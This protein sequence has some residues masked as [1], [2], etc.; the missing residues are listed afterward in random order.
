MPIAL[1]ASSLRRVCT[2]YIAVVAAITLAF[3]ALNARVAHPWI[4]G[5]WLI[6]YSGGFLRRGLLGALLLAVHQHTHLP[7]LPLTSALQITLYAAFYTSLLPL[8]RGLRWSLPLLTLLL[9]PAT[10]AFTVLDPPTSVRKEVLL[11]LALSLL[12][13]LVVSRRTPAWQLSLAL[14]IAAPVLILAH[15]ALLAFLPYLF[16]PLLLATSH[17]RDAARF[18]LP[19]I[20][21]AALAFAA[22][23]SHPGGSREATAICTSIGSHL[24]HQPAGICS[25]AIAYLELTPVQARAETLRAIRVYSYRTRYPLPVLLTSLPIA[26][27]F[28]DRSRRR[29]NRR[30]NNQCP[31]NQH[32]GNQRPD[33]L[34]LAVTAISLLASLPL[35]VIARDWGRWTEIHATCLL[36]LFLLLERLVP[37]AASDLASEPRPAVSTTALSVTPFSLV[38]L[39]LYTTCWTLPSVGIFPGRFGY[40]DLARYLRSY[41]GKPHLST[42]PLSPTSLH[43]TTPLP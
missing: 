31:G 9:S 22:A 29:S 23:V 5:E 14:S 33:R 8:L 34:L 43:S 4:V 20:L 28:A 36:L 40:V 37:S 15:E 13:N 10:L 3:A 18:V 12:V 39:L 42:A 25:G 26:W 7:L 41:H 19:P 11:F 17:L 2:L 27:L 1:S 30:G 32:S 35:F 16:L 38:G 6:N 21:L 24:D